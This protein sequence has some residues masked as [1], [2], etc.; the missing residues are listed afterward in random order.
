MLHPGYGFL[1]EN[2]DFAQAV[3]DAGIVWLGPRPSVIKTMGLK[4]VAREV[5][6]QANLACVPGSEGLVNDETTALQV[7]RRIGF[8]VM[9]K[10][11]A[12]GGG[13]GMVIC[14]DEQAL[15]D[16]FSR[17]QKRAEASLATSPSSYCY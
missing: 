12:G 16:A 17:V 14:E 7:A 6:V 15:I 5:A 11:S 3:L 4:H 8:P 10:A 1:S 9:V 2:A 13:M